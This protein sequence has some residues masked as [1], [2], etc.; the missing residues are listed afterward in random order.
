MA[1]IFPI[2]A[3]L[4]DLAGNE[5]IATWIFVDNRKV[6]FPIPNREVTDNNRIG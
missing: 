1:G 6:V 5:N 3:G 2:I 4:L